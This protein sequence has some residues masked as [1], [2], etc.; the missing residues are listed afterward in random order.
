MKEIEV[1]LWKLYSRRLANG[2]VEGWRGLREKKKVK[3]ERAL[4]RCLVGGERML[5]RREGYR[6]SAICFALVVSLI[7][8]FILLAEAFS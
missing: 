4:L 1:R 2:Y 5:G 6:F 3:S 8:V 7:Y